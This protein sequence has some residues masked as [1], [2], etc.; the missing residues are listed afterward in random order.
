MQVY[1]TDLN[2]QKI[3]ADGKICFQ[4]VIVTWKG[5]VGQRVQHLVL[6]HN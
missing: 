5:A 1:M 2:I 6:C 3:Y 4:V